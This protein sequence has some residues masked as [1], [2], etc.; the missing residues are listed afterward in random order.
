MPM[1]LDIDEQ[2]YLRLLQ[3][4]DADRV[5]ELTNQN[6][7]YLSEWLP[8]VDSTQSVDDTKAFLDMVEGHHAAKKG[9]H[10]CVVFQEQLVGLI[11]LRFNAET[12]VTNLGYWLSADASGRGLMTRAVQ[13]LCRY[14][15]DEL[16]VE[17]IEI[18]AATDNSR[19]WEIP[20]RLGF[21]REGVLRRCE[22]IADRYLDHYMY[23]LIRTDKVDWL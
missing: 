9:V 15:F 17:R 20:E 14:A 12:Y 19:S 1:R 18:R 11:G 16:N 3:L 8:W 21:T 4:T 6:R 10:C 23:S 5:F 7:A 22:K 2:T 13:T